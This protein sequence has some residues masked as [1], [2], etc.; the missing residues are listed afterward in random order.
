MAASCA[1]TDI[2]RRLLI[3]EDDPAS[4]EAMSDVLGDLG[5]AV[6]CAS[7]DREAYARLTTTS[8]LAGLIVDVNL[9]PGT[10]GFDVARFA[11]QLHPDL[12]VLYVTG[13]A[14]QES[15]KAFG[16]PDSEYI[17]KPYGVGELLRLVQSRIAAND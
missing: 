1:E 15:F 6:L 4:C 14:S 12:P 7:T 17:A 10:T 9:G 8:N 11:R 2:H 5:F 16:V 3:V 13:E